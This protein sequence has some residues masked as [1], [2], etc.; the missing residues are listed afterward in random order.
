MKIKLPKWEDAALYAD[1]E[2]DCLSAR[3]RVPGGWIYLVTR[4]ELGA[5]ICFVPEPK[6][7]PHAP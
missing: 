7:P 1:G 4:T 6:E 3:L 5:G 2:L